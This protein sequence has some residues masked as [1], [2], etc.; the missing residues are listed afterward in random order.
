[1]SSVRVMD[2]PEPGLSSLIIT[3]T[4]LPALRGAAMVRLIARSDLT[5]GEPGGNWVPA[6][7]TNDDPCEAFRELESIPGVELVEVVFVELPASAA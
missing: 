4:A 5:L 2:A 6:V 1:M 7:L 3:L